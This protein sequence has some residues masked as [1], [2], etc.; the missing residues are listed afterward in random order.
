M[1]ASS[2]VPPSSPFL[3]RYMV[4]SCAPREACQRL[5]VKSIAIASF[6]SQWRLTDTSR[7]RSSSRLTSNSGIQR[8]AGKMVKEV[9]L[10]KIGPLVAERK[11]G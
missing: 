1:T 7:L 10:A 8:G 4:L 9:S 11:V 3:Q 6:P 2:L 5:P